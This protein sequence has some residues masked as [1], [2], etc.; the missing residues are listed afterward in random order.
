MVIYDLTK[1]PYSSRNGSYGGAASDKDGILIDNEGI[2]F[3]VK[4]MKRFCLSK[5]GSTIL[6]RK[7]ID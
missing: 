1:C 6:L 2:G 7:Q 3:I 5:T 4:K